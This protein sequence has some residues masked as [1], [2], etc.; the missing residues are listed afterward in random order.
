VLGD[1][2]VQPGRHR[3]APEV[4]YAPHASVEIVNPAGTGRP[5]FTISARFALLLPRRSFWSL[6][7]SEKS[8]T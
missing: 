4:R 1:L 7:P 3:T 8:K 5:S 2:R 6:S